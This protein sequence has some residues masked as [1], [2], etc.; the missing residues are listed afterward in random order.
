MP[1]EQ[2]PLD[3]HGTY[4]DLGDWGSKHGSLH[5]YAPCPLH[6][7]QSTQ[8]HIFQ[9]L[10][11]VWIKWS[12]CLIVAP[13]LRALLLLLGGLVRP[14]C[15]WFLSPII[16]LSYLPYLLAAYSFLLRDRTEWVQRRVRD[17]KVAGRRGGKKSCNQ[18]ILYKKRNL[19]SITG[20]Y[21]ILDVLLSWETRPKHI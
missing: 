9:W 1:W 8:G 6:V 3:Q 12:G 2:G 21:K 5:R 4:C 10:L 13:T 14:W 20:K 16:F 7:D 17:G 19:V 11:S 15:Y 18:N